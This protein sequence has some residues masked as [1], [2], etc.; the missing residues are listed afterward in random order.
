MTTGQD[1]LEARL[2]RMEDIHAIRQLVGRYSLAV[3]DHD[4]AALHAVFAADAMYGWH[5]REPDARGRDAVVELLRSRIA[6]A[7]PSFHVNHDHL[8]D[9]DEAAPDQ[10]TGV[11]FAHAEGSPGGRQ[12]VNAIR[13]HD[14]YVRER[15]GWRIRDRRLA[16]LYITPAED[17][18]GVLLARNRLRHVEPAQ[19]A[20][21]PQF[22]G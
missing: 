7:G 2:R 20:H 14:T 12:M 3:D 19:P 18:A 13:Y 21:W 22:A 4:F 5:G 17:Y 1:G 16:F 9:W 15:E 8:I 11:V 10:A 6:P